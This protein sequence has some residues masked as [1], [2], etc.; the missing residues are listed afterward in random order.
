MKGV[1]KDKV[2]RIRNLEK[3]A[4]S[5]F[6][7]AYSLKREIDN[8][9]ASEADDY[10]DSYV[11]VFT[12]RFGYSYMKVERQVV[13]TKALIGLWLFGPCLTLSD[14]PLTCEENE[15]GDADEMHYE[16]DGRIFVDVPAL[17]DESL[18][19]IRKLSKEEV[20]RVCEYCHKIVKEKLGV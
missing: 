19:S 13:D 18:T 16:E 14:N 9:V 1:N 12:G 20:E 17:N 2:D 11:E 6:D 15:D 4:G 7:K 10:T 3:E 8:I 5:L